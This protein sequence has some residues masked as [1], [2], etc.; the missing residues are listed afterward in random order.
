M[1]KFSIHQFSSGIIN[2]KQ[3]TI[4]NEWV[5]GGYGK[6]IEKESYDVPPEIKRAV[7][8]SSKEGWRG[9]GIKDNY[10]PPM[11]NYAL[12]A[13]ELENY[14]VLAVAN[15]HKDDANR[16]FTAYRYFWLDKQ[17]FKNKPN[18]DDFDGIG[19]LLYYWKQ[20]GNPQYDIGE[21]TNHP[22][23]YT[24][25][26]EQTEWETKTKSCQQSSQ[27]LQELI[28]SISSDNKPLIY[29]ANQIDCSL[30]PEEVHCLAIKY[31]LEK[32]C[33]INWAWNVRRLESMKDLRVIFCADAKA[34]KW[35]YEQLI[36][37]GPTS[38]TSVIEKG[39][40]S[41]HNPN[42]EIKDLLLKLCEN[43]VEE[44]VLKLMNYCLKD[45]QNIMEVKDEKL[46]N[47]FQSQMP[48]PE[49]KSIKYAT[50]LTAL[51]PDKHKNILGSLKKLNS[52]LKNEVAINFLDNL[53]KILTQKS[54]CFKHKKCQFF[55]KKITSIRWQLYDSV[56]ETI[57]R[58]KINILK[59]LNNYPFIKNKPG[60]NK[61]DSEERKDSGKE[62]TDEKKRK[63]LL[64][65]RGKFSEKD[66]L[67]LIDNYETI[68]KFKDE[69]N[70]NY[71]S[72][73]NLEV[74]PQNIKYATLLT[75]LDPEEKENILNS[76]ISLNDKLKKNVAIK[77]LDK[78][79][80]M[81]T[82]DLECFNNPNYQVFC[83]KITYTKFK[84]INS[85]DQNTDMAFPTG[86]VLPLIPFFLLG[87]VVFAWLYSQPKIS[88]T[89]STTRNESENLLGTFEIPPTSTG[90]QGSLV[91]LIN[92]Y[93]SQYEAIKILE[94]NN[95]NNANN[96]I[97]QEF[98]KNLYEQLD[99]YQQKITNKLI[100]AEAEEYIRQ[101][102]GDK[103]QVIN[104]RTKEIYTNLKQF[105]PKIIRE[106]LPLLELGKQDQNKVNVTALQ[107]ALQRSG[108]YTAG[109]ESYKIGKF[110]ELTKKAVENLQNTNIK[111]LQ[112]QGKKTNMETD[113]K[114]RTNT[115]NL[116]TGR[117]NDLQV[118]MVY[119]TLKKHLQFKNQTGYNIVSE[120][121]RCKDNNQNEKAL[122]FV[123][124]LEK[125][126]DKP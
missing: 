75:A 50:L 36:N 53:L 91:E 105:T 44:N 115:W 56:A 45:R 42:N 16:P 72:Q 104:A 68:L 33:S 59:E 85:L 62:I 92:K 19:T 15:Q 110:D 74:K 37:D 86:I 78:L 8:M 109:Q 67:R 55:C 49:H 100:Y 90:K 118:E 125:L 65:F 77:L 101:L 9:F 2:P 23:S 60:L 14:C 51:F 89:I 111:N 103:N 22:D 32:K 26:W 66:V 11:N 108:H 113:G 46:I 114:V 120:I 63:L 31:S 17:E 12:I 64:K 48:N 123:N 58:L 117:L 34:F 57:Y 102:T 116:L 84:L 1:S 96:E 38:D 18:V 6:E 76:L 73:N 25:S 39:E 94:A 69:N 43:C 121:K 80:M 7:N 87:S 119:E 27:R 24:T 81:A 3:N 4:N 40:D 99:R 41:K 29:E 126:N 97:I 28:S 83:H 107:N 61:H 82:I 20:K 13:R 71:D 5:S 70:I 52:K 88:I 124:C 93:D 10:P 98:K 95:K 122:G 112:K 30:E 54:S 21:W 79:L 47:E 35:F 106:K